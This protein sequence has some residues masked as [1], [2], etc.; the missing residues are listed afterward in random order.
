MTSR[1]YD[2]IVI[3]AGAGGLIAATFAAQLGAKV[4][5]VE[6]GRIGGDCTWTGCVPSKALIK[7]ARVA[8]EA[9]HAGKYGVTVGVTGV[10]MA[11]V[12]RY[13]QEA[14]AGVYRHETPEQL[15][16]RGIEVIVGAARFLEPHTIQA[17]GRM[18]SAKRFLI[19]TGA[20]PS[21]P[22]FIRQSGL[23]FLTYEQLFDNEVLPQRF[24]VMGA[25]PTGVEMAQAYQRLGSQVTLIDSALLPGEEPEV[26]AVLGRAFARE[27]IQFIPGQV[28]AARQEKGEIVLEVEGKRIG[29]DTLLVATGRHPNVAGLDLE[30]A[31]VA[32][33]AEG[34]QV[35]RYLRTSARHIYAAGD[36]IG[37]YQLAHFAGWQAFQA[38]RNALLPGKSEGVTDVVPQATFTDPEVAR[39]GLTEGE[40]RQQHGNA[41]R[42]AFW[43]NAHTDRAVSED[44]RD[45]FI[46][47]VHTEDGSIIGAT[48]V[49]GRAGEIINEFALALQH[50]LTLRDLASAI[51]VYPT[52]AT[53]IM[54]LAADVATRQFF[55]SLFGRLV[56]GLAGIE[57]DKFK[58]VAA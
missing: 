31:G 47:V 28:S 57:A 12:R 25:G 23:P 8:H 16:A 40:A 2:F 42:I 44:D 32:F 11:D 50:N 24:I 37:S 10:N 7:A 41:V 46:K 6:K 51:H 53:A 26:A 36:C 5:L 20:S 58:D 49:A 3:G 56:K 19:C 22:P 27:G 13:V 54:Q 48:A 38:T 21:V 1:P 55:S 52:Y 30:K 45:G 4:A 9:R 14:I 39:V 33:S 17:G 34:I 43:D 29:G 15:E 18:L 35:D